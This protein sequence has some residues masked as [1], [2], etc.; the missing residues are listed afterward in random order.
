[1]NWAASI[2]VIWSV[3]CSKRSS[4]G[5]P[6]ALLVMIMTSQAGWPNGCDRVWFRCRAAGGPCPVSMESRRRRAALAR[7]AAPPWHTGRRPGAFV[8]RCGSA[9]GRGP[10]LCRLIEIPGRWQ[11]RVA[12]ERIAGVDVT[13]VPP[14]CRWRR[15]ARRRSLRPGP[16]LS[17]SH[18]RSGTR[19]RRRPR[20]GPRGPAAAQPT[21]APLSAGSWDSDSWVLAMQTGIQPKPLRS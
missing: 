12:L 3:T 14:R 10:A 6:G 21:G 19:S 20:P 1:M 16:A 9:A 5:H 7:T 13:P 11:V 8:G 15:C 2:L 17:A 4:R 18:R